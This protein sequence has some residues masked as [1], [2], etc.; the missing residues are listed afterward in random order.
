M[1]DYGDYT[2]VQK[3][4]TLAGYLEHFRNVSIDNDIP[5]LLSFFYVQGQIAAPFV[6][7][8]IGGSYID[9]RVHVFWI[10]SSRTGKSISW[11]FFG[12]LLEK[13]NL[14]TAVH[15]GGS[16]AGL[17]GG[18]TQRDNEIETTTGLLDGQCA[19][20]FDEGSMLLKPGKH[21]KDTVL[22]L[23]TACN[24]IGNNK[25]EK[26]L[27]D[28]SIIT[29]SMASIWATTF[30]PDGVK[31]YVL[32]KGIFQRVL[33]YWRDWTDSM[34]QRV[35]ESRM[36][37][38]FGPE[39]EHEMDETKLVDYF[40]GLEN[41]LRNR[42]LEVY[43]MEITEWQAL[44]REDREQI[45]QKVKRKV[46]SKSES[47]DPT[48]MQIIDDYYSL[49]S[50][51]DAKLR[52][53]VLSFIPAMENYTIILATHMAMLEETWVVN[54][55]HLDMAKDIL[56]DLYQ[57]LIIWLEEEVEVG[58]KAADK[59]ARDERWK[60]SIKAV[61]TFD[62]DSRGEG[63]A[64]KREVLTKYGKLKNLSK[65]AQFR[66]F[67]K[68]KMLFDATREGAAVYIRLKDNS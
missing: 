56:Y 28:G 13:C 7:I 24:P 23:Q 59:R 61:E 27:K 44:G 47:F 67:D 66:H 64:R 6:R 38:V 39:P 17:I 10:Q 9:P 30:P 50:N 51:I 36:E 12:K 20:N 62:L 43:A 8:P 18:H 55:E 3:Y 11:E 58:Q 48:M 22:Y 45:V 60:E 52:E 21:S 4:S 14:R 32:T 15:M 35:S 63:W 65:N 25:I 68:S 2:A 46:F 42:I 26:F 19:L 57:N 54:G 1:R 34:R 40:L 41:R 29:N 16:D 33:L 5:G 37:G 53:V 31:D 49:V